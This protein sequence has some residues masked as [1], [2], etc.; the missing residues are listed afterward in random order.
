MPKGVPLARRRELLIAR[1][2]ATAED[3]QVPCYRFLATWTAAYS[4][5]YPKVRGATE[6][7]TACVLE[8]EVSVYMTYVMFPSRRRTPSISVLLPEQA[9][10]EPIRTSQEAQ[11]LVGHLRYI[12]E[13]ESC[14]REIDGVKQLRTAI[15]PCELQ[16]WGTTWL[17][18]HL[19]CPYELE[20][21]PPVFALALSMNET[22]EL[23]DYIADR[24]IKPTVPS[25]PAPY[26]KRAHAQHLQEV[27]CGSS[28]GQKKQKTH[29]NKKSPVPATCHSCEPPTE[30]EMK[31]ELDS[32]GTGPWSKYETK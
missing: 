25:T 4:E 17:D 16:S 6:C 21:V 13:R 14:Q 31:Q 29:A 8:G 32:K 28:I 12:A 22:E 1:S 27:T 10:I 9:H 2:E 19:N 3:I 5:C 15:H 23:S 18:C 24:T 30:S 26:L 7:V 20:K 11:R